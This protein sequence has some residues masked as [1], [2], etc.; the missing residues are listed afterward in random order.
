MQAQTLSDPQD[1]AVSRIYSF[2][3]NKESSLGEAIKGYRLIHGLSQKKLAKN[4]GIDPTTLARWESGTSK[5]G[6]RLR[7]RLAGLLGDSADG[8]SQKTPTA[9]QPSP[10]A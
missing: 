6:T 4:L 9:T 1:S 3:Y 2:P 8:V 5:P 10:F 7:E